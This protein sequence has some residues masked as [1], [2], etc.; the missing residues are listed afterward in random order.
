MAWDKVTLE[1]S[2]CPYQEPVS[3]YQLIIYNLVTPV[4]VPGFPS[5]QVDNTSWTIKKATSAAVN[6]R[7]SAWLSPD[8]WTSSQW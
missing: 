7:S 6:L 2:C 5:S 4:R 1:Q 8:Q 3:G